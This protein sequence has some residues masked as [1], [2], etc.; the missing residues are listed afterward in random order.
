MDNA[1]KAKEQ[2]GMKISE[3]ELFIQEFTNEITSCN[4]K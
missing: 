3:K 4:M 2:L 1:E